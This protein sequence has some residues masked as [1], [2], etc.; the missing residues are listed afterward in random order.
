MGHTMCGAVKAAFHDT[1]KG[2]V[3]NI[4]NEIKN[5]IG[6]EDNYLK[7]V[8]LNAINSLNKIK[9]SK[10]INEFS[11]VKVI[12]SIYHTHSGKVEFFRK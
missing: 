10:I 6:T 4:V 7:C 8:K 9:E 5:A 2:D 11:D 12:N 3:L 1:H